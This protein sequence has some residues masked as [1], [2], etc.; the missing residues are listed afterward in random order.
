MFE[1]R[2]VAV[3]VDF[4]RG[5]ITVFVH[6]VIWPVDGRPRVQWGDLYAAAGEVPRRDETARIIGCAGR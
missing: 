3:N 4:G 2:L 5:I 1:T 6:G